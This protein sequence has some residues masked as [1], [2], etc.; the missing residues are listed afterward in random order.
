M[1]QDDRHQDRII[2]AL[3][4]LRGKIEAAVFNA[5]DDH[6]C[7]GIIAQALHGHQA[8]AEPYAADSDCAGR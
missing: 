7:G 5:A 1:S 6:R 4:A 8:R 3:A 2:V